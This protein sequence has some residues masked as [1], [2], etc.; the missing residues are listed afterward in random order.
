MDLVVK[1]WSEVS[2]AAAAAK[3]ATEERGIK[4]PPP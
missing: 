1:L 2:E 3:G 4:P